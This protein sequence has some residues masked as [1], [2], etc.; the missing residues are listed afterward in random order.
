MKS[1]NVLVIDD[2]LYICETI[3][4]ILQSR[5]HNTQTTI[6]SHEGLVL[7]AKHE[8][9]I[10][11]TDY[12]MPFIRGDELAR[13]MKTLKPTVPICVI[14]GSPDELQPEALGQFAAVVGKPFT[15][16]NLT[17]ALERVLASSSASV[18]GTTRAQRYPVDWRIDYVLLQASLLAQP[19]LKPQ[20]TTLINLAEGGFGFVTSEELPISSLFALVIHPPESAKPFLSIGQVRWQRMVEGKN[21]VG[22]KWLLWEF[23]QEKDLAV[24]YAH[25]ETAPTA[26]R[27]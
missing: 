12:R 8:Y 22:A 4:A 17:E 14:T 21:A 25:G 1:L 10:V 26:H 23:E 27:Q 13:R 15:I 5:G 20:R 9:D 6:D 11:F 24:T 3:R 2:K 19:S 16:A 18:N 7:F